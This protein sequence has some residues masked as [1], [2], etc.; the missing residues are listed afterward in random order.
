MSIPHHVQP[1]QP[2]DEAPVVRLWNRALG[3]TLPLLPRL[4]HQGTLGDPDL[5]P[6]D[7][8]VAR[9]GGQVIGFVLARTRP[10]AAGIDPETGWLEAVI[11]DPAYQRRGL[12]RELVAHA[13]EYL[14][15]KGV[16]H[17]WAGGGPTMFFPGPSTLLPGAQRFLEHCGYAPVQEVFDVLGNLETMPRLARVD[18]ALRAA[19]ARVCPCAE[20][21]WELLDR[22]LAQHFPGNWREDRRR[23]RAMGAPSDEIYLLWV[24]G[25]IAGF[26]QTYRGDSPV[27]GPNVHWGPALGVAEGGLGPIGVAQ[28]WRGRGLGLAVLAQALE[29]LR[30]RGV[31]H[32]VIDWT[33]L[34]D[35]YGI[36]GFR[37]WRSYIR[38]RKDLA[39]GQ[40]SPK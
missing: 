13:E 32:C 19:G 16:K 22:F 9:H 14:A 2:G 24:G 26:A 35:F 18:E 27:L 5:Q 1:L 10:P 39:P 34:L 30:S 3:D 31:R 4:L 38:M 12:G 37:V 28:A 8:L 25:E 20:E 21:E 29:G 23:H 40:S 7:A 33:R 11:V 17:I 36:L 6:G 15:S